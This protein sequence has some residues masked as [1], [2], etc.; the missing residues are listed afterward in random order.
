MHILSK[1]NKAS[2]H[3]FVDN[4]D[5]YDLLA[6]KRMVY[7]LDFELLHCAHKAPSNRFSKRLSVLFQPGDGRS[8][9]QPSIIRCHLQISNISTDYL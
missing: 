7:L 2:V 3:Q 1:V 8:P 5:S 9:S 6:L 4:I